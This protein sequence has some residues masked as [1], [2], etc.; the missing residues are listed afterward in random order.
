LCAALPCVHTVLLQALGECSDADQAL[1][2]A[3]GVCCE[4]QALGAAGQ[5]LPAHV[6]RKLQMLLGVLQAQGA[7]GAQGA[8]AAAAGDA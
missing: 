6:S 3:H 2:R 1:R 8:V 7:G 5:E 4:V